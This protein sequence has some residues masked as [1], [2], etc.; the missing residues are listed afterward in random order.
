MERR[1]RFTAQGQV[2][3]VG[4]R[5]FVFT[6]AERCALTGFVLN[7][8]RG[9]VIEVQG[10]AK[11][12]ER[13]A[14]AL[15]TQLPPLARLTSLESEDCL[16][17]QGETAFVIGSSIEGSSHCVLV[18]PDVCMCDACLHDIRS[19]ENRRFRYPF[20]NCTN[21]GPRYSITRSIPYDRPATSM[22][23]FPLCREC[24]AEYE[25]PRDRRFHAQPNACPV[26]G[27]QVWL[28]VGAGF[29][30]RV[31]F[32]N[33]SIC[34]RTIFSPLAAENLSGLRGDEALR[35]AAAVLADGGIVA[36]K[37]LGGFHLACHAGNETATALL[38]RRKHRPH[39]PFAVMAPE[40]QDA[41]RIAELHAEE[42]A[43]LC[44]P[45]H[46]IVICRLRTGGSS[47]LVAGNVSPDT[48][49]IGLML[50]YT[51]LHRVLM[52]YFAEALQQRQMMK[53]DVDGVGTPPANDASSFPPALLVM[54]SGNPSGEPICLGNREALA[55]LSGMADLFLLHNR[56][57]LNRVDDSV[58]RVI[59]GGGTL[60]YRRA[61]GYVPRPTPLHSRQEDGVPDASPVIL[62]VGA[63]LKNTLCLTK[64][65]D[66]FVS[67]HI[68]DMANLETSAFHGEIREHLLSL[69]KV[70]PQV[71]VRDLHPDYPSSALAEQL[72]REM[73]IPLLRL[74]HHFAHAHAVLAE[75]QHMEPALALT[76]DGT[77]LGDDG[78]LWGGELLYIHPCGPNGPEHKRLAR[79]APLALPGGEAAIRE[80]WRI[81]HALL[82]RLG[83]FEP[84]VYSP[85]WLPE[86][87]KAAALLPR[88]LERGF[89]TPYSSSAGRLFDAVSA[90]L[91]LGVAISYEGQAAI[92]LEEAQHAPCPEQTPEEEHRCYPCSFAPA[93]SLPGSGTSAPGLWQL[94]T[95][96]LF[97][98]V[99]ADLCQKTP[100]PLIARRFH[101]SLACA[102]AELTACMA[103]RC[104]CSYVGL[105]G[106]CLQNLSLLLLLKAA[107][108]SKGLIPLTH[109][110]FPPG[111]GCISLGQAAWASLK[112]S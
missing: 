38:R 1:I 108:E 101:R 90:L 42:K 112:R 87:E 53:R 16:P 20:T 35:G 67:Q 23:C 92:R 43:L 70:R 14:H 28:E 73:D 30:D 7:S 60:F 109:K 69:L 24:E 62:G 27:P 94:N 15:A 49:S 103:Q 55:K 34:Y 36:V 19:P 75:H 95:H 39:K 51:P 102:L 52:D 37:G 61:R 48:A 81:A 86:Y 85:P 21:C 44:S 89:N 41:E 3:G 40:L 74:Q 99:Y 104:A 82:L 12:L 78:Q 72:S 50:P 54:T 33:D 6:L 71:I 32:D 110:D 31:A 84:A 57:I 97:A 107:L 105:S 93:A 76:L 106:G 8:P 13:F 100:V 9:V 45:E 83:L 47:K 79:F 25:N 10:G 26:C 29:F 46:P 80:P 65:N 88:M 66:A 64:A 56:D 18:S 2:Q 111:D 96:E 98:A 91:G 22:A 17:L 5:P 11:D 77:G 58:A 68:G 59:P 63:E 4:F